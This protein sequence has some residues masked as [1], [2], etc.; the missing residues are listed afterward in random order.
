MIKVTRNLHDGMQARVQLDF[1]GRSSCFQVCQGLRQGQIHPPQMFKIFSAAFVDGVSQQFVADPAIIQGV[2]SRSCAKRDEG[3]PLEDTPP[4]EMRRAV[5]GK[6]IRM[7]PAL[8]R[9]PQMG[10]TE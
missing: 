9:G 2:V 1:G 6:L 7:T 8:S 10:L 3:E 5:R 4:E